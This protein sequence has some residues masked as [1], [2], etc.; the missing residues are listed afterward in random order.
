MLSPT[1][2][3]AAMESVLLGLT[4]V[5]APRAAGVLG[6]ATQTYWRRLAAHF[7]PLPHLYSQLDFALD[8]LKEVRY[9]APALRC[10]V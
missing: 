2:G 1:S 5:T 4:D 7:K 6:V 8:A 10:Y 3:V 9:S